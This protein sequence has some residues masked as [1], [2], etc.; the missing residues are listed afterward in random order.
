MESISSSGLAEIGDLLRRAWEIYKRRIWTLTGLGLSTAFVAILISVGPVGLGFLISQMMPDFKGVIMPVS[1]L[2]TILGTIWVVNWGAAAFFTAV[3]DQTCGIREAFRLAKPKVFAHMWLSVLS[4]LIISGAHLLLVIPGIIFTVWFFFTPF[5]FIDEDVRGMNAL[6]KSKEYVR[7]RWFGVCWRLIVIWAI[8]AL[9]SG[10]PIIGQLLALFLIPFSLVYTFLVYKDLKATRGEIY[11]QPTIKAKAGIIATGTLG[12][13]AIPA[14]LIVIMGSMLLMPFL[15]LKAKLTG[16]SPAAVA[17]GG[18]KP[19]RPG[20]NTARVLQPAGGNI[21]A[22]IQILEDK[23]KEW[24]ERAQAAF[25]LGRAKDKRAV[26]PLIRALRDD[27]KRGVRQ[28]AMEGLGK[29]GDS[30][31]VEPLVHALESDSNVFV[32]CDAAIVLGKLGDRRA[33]QALTKALKD[34]EIVHTFKDGKTLQ[35]KVVAKAAREALQKLGV[36]AG[37]VAEKSRVG[38]VA[39]PRPTISADPAKIEVDTRIP[40]DKTKSLGERVRAARSLGQTRD[41]RAI[42]ACTEAID[43]NP[44][45]FAAYHN[46]GLANSRLGNYREAVADFTKAIELEPKSAEA[47]YNRAIAYGA[48]DKNA[49]AIEDGTRAIELNPKDAN[50]YINRGIDYIGIGN[51]GKAV[52]DLNKA[53]ELNA[54]DAAAYY[55]RGYA[56]QKLSTFERALPDF[57]KSAKMGYKKAEAYLRSRASL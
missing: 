12:Y 25:R 22:D 27:D 53:I 42:E 16:E 52:A 40:E 24:T 20:V 28:R 9:I 8:S 15:M 37:Q 49:K 10:I 43:L 38:K 14:I 13:V 18:V 19:H 7:G 23:S 4:G 6:L 32:R 31:A 17:I 3:V 51:Y 5:V 26:E 30:R 36:T 1:M 34:Q 56:H 2:L 44:S 35:V 33:V 48:L 50:A 21:D 47:H 55:A 39:T 57:R 11:L 41:K 45:D 54:Q 46:R 29:L